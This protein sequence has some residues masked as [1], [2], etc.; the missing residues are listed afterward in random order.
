MV[1]DLEDWAARV[2]SSIVRFWGV[3]SSSVGLWVGG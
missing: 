3:R 1:S 2:G